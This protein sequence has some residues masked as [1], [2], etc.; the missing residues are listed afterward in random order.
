M[1][2]R[3]GTVQALP[4]WLTFNAAT[5]TFTGTAPGTAQTVNILVTATDSSGLSV[6]EQ[7]AAA[8]APP[9]VVSAATKAQTWL[10]GQA[11]SLTL[12]AAT[13]ADPQ[14][15]KLSYKAALA[16]GQALPGWLTFNAA[17]ETFSGTAPAAAQTL[18]IVVTAT[19]TLGLS[20]SET[21]AAAVI[22]APVVA[23]ATAAQTW[24][25]GKGISLALPAA[26]FADPQGEKLTWT[27]ALAGGQA[28]PNWLT[29]N[30][31]TETFTGTAPSSYQTLSI[32]VTATNSSGLSA[33][34]TISA[35]VAGAPVLTAATPAQS[36][37]E[38][39]AISLALPAGTFADPQGEN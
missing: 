10:A 8:V 6:S 25:E 22:G 3:C 2:P 26:T 15:L 12:P 34:E 7:F 24:V 11:I 1:R 20:A 37:V 16:N 21:I 35:T 18:S 23:A 5:Q 27:A 9:P 14:G 36:W 29:F 4:G 13:F 33:S 28:L 17:T 32:V 19:D 30:A 38:G 39:K 31:A